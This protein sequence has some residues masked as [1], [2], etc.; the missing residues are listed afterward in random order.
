[1]RNITL[2]TVTHVLSSVQYDNS[3]LCKFFSIEMDIYRHQKTL[4]IL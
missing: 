2:R 1:M 4:S 3:V